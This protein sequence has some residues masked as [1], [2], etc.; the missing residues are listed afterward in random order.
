[1]PI[2]TTK[3]KSITVMP[4]TGSL[5]IFKTYYQFEIMFYLY[6]KRPVMKTVKY[7][8]QNKPKAMYSVS[9]EISVFEALNVMF[10]KNISALLITDND[11]LLGIFTERDYARKIVLKGKSSKDT[12]VNEVMTSAPLTISLN[13]EIDLCMQIMTEKHIRHLPVTEQ[14]KVIGM[15]SIGDVVK[16]IIEIQKETI[17]HLES[18]INS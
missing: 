12:L 6:I 13:D 18:Y 4:Q 8:L 2:H 11:E 1:M 17:K 7:I 16:S 15:V 3:E 14:G 9:S 5:K 10:D